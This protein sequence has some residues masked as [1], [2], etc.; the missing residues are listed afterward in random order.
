MTHISQTDRRQLESLQR[1][2]L[3]SLQLEKLNKLLAKIVPANKFYREKLADCPLSLATLDELQQLPFTT[4][5]ELQSAESLPANLTWPI[6]SYARFH[7]T[8]GTHGRP[9]PVYDTQRDWQWWIDCWQFV[10]DA[11]NVTD[12]DRALLAFSFGPFIG[13]W[14]A[15]DALVQRGALVIPAG[16]TD[17]LGRIDL[18]R[19]TSATTLLATPTYALRLA[20]VAA[21]NSIDLAGSSI[22]KII[23]A[24]EPGGS[25]AAVRSRIE[26]AWNATVTDHAGAS[27]IGAWGYGDQERR[28]LRLLESEFLAEFIAVDHGGPAQNGELA[29]LVLTTLGRPGMPVVRYRTGDLVRPDWTSDHGN[30]FVLLDGGVLGRADDMLVIRG[31]NIFPSSIDE[32]VR[33][34]PEIVEYRM[35]ASKQGAMDALSLEVEDRLQNPQRIAEALH[36]G[37]GLTID[38]RLA[39]ADSLP[40]FEGKGRRFVDKRGNGDGATD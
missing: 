13:F 9:L 5:D 6:S 36:L 14:S 20:E 29:H 30:R 40:R 35:I 10:L 26:E 8:S 25:V 21:A 12:S 7:Q 24:G 3:E 38:V 32:I 2:A 31:V 39:A 17:S 23:V 19:R 28:G 37:L 1:P 33:G 11:A 4:K 34:F 22:E 15:H 16:G 18:I 27:E